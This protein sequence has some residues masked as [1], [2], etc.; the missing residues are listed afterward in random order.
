VV[1]D[2]STDNSRDVIASYGDRV[3][4]VLKEQQ[5]QASTFNAGFA[6]SCGDVVVFLDADDLLLPTALERAL[7][8][9]VDLDVAKVHWPL[10]VIDESGRRTGDVHPRDHL[11][12]GCLRDAAIRR[13]PMSH[14]S[15]PTSGNAWARWYLKRV[16]PVHDYGDRH[17]GDAYLIDLAPIYGLIRALEEPQGCYRVHSRNF[18]G[19]SR[20]FRR[21]LDLRRYPDEC[22]VLSEHLHRMGVDVEPAEWMGPDTPFSWMKTLDE[23]TRSLEACVPVG[24]TFILVDDNQWGDPWG[25]DKVLPN[26]STLPFLERDGEHWGAPSDDETAIRELE[27]L[28]AKGASHIAFAWSAFWWLEHYSEFA[29]YLTHRFRRVVDT[30]TIVAFDLRREAAD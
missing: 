11:S 21:Q 13:G 8:H 3:I 14:V 27:R 22:R 7:P 26:R 23:A 1:D 19:K 17:G 30:E 25:P 4:P 12:D 20:Q 6:A 29:H 5:G 28:R 10:W 16:L 2:G 18:S 24:E 15:P 9:F